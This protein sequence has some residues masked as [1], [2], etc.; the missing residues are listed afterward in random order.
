MKRGAYR[1]EGGRRDH[2]L[3]AI[4]YVLKKDGPLVPLLNE[5]GEI[6]TFPKA[7]VYGALYGQINEAHYVI[8]A[9]ERFDELPVIR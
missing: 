3:R 2:S 8:K 6:V 9:M 1:Q 7:A 5:K 4:G